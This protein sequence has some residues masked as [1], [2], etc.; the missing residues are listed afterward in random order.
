LQIHKVGRL[1]EEF[2]YSILV[3]FAGGGSL[4]GNM[5]KAQRAKVRT[6]IKKGLQF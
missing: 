4:S 3:A 2:S 5:D 6:K 1:Q